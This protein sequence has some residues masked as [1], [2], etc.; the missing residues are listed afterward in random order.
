MRLQL[1]RLMNLTIP[2][3]QSK[4]ITLGHQDELDQF[5]LSSKS[6][7]ESV[8]PLLARLGMLKAFRK[9]VSPLSARGY[10]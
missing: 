4:V 6:V 10:F 1:S 2:R 5:M 9:R 3:R 8:F 7:L